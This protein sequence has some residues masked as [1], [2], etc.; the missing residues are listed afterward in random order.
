MA[1]D[2]GRTDPG[3]RLQLVC[4]PLVAEQA[5]SLS[6]HLAARI[7]QRYEIEGRAELAR[8]HLDVRPL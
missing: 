8:D 6:P 5:A 4:H 3:G 7:G 2:A 1:E